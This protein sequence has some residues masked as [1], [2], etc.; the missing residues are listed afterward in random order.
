MN[1][2]IEN[3]YLRIT[4][5]DIGAELVSV[6]S[7]SDGC[8]YVWQ[9]DE[10]YWKGQAPLL[11]P[12]C[13]RLFGGYYTYEG[14]QYFMKSHGFL[15][16]NP[17]DGATVN[18]NSVTVTLTPNDL[19]RS[20]YPFDFALKVTYVL[21]GKKVHVGFTVKNPSSNKELIFTLGGHP[22]FNAP[23]DKGSF[24]DWYLEFGDTATPEQICFSD[25]CFQTGRTASFALKEGN[26]LPLKHELFDNDAIFLHGMASSVTL[27]S[28]MSDKSVRLDYPD[29]KYLGIWHPVKKDA[30][31]VCIE[32]MNGLPSFD[33]KVDDLATKSDMIRLDPQS[34][35]TA[36]FDITF[37]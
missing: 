14:N 35:Y 29:M 30:P 16:N 3:E 5:S 31:F 2:S 6:I 32:P 4:V 13:C 25:S 8:E 27:K 36:G 26:V 23:I 21:E 34:D 37:N 7:K 33:G 10:R 28:K 12:I 20:Q 17:C 19:T 1:Y 9:G 11:F 15:R 22:G 24:E 18:G